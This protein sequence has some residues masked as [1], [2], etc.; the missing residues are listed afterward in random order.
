L[1]I[2]IVTTPNETLKETGLGP[3]LACEALMQSLLDS[4]HMA[5]VTVCETEADLDLVV[6]R[7]PDL[8]VCVVKYICPENVKQIWLS[9]FFE[10][11]GINY[12]G[13]KK[14]NLL[15]DS[16]K[17]SAKLIVTSKGI[18]TAGFFVAIPGQH[19]NETELPLPF[20][21]FIKPSD[22][23]NGN[24][25]DILSLVHDFS[26]F[27]EKVKNLYAE[28]GEPV[29][30]EEYL[31]GMEFTVAVIENEGELIIAPIEVIAQEEGGIRILGS[32]AKNNNNEILR[33]ITDADIMAK[34]VD[35]AGKSFRALGAR[36]FGR[37]DVKM[38]HHG[39]CHFIEA[40]LVPGMK[41]GSSYFPRACEM[42]AGLDYN[43]V[44]RLMIQGATQ[45]NG[46]QHPD[47]AEELIPDGNAGLA[48]AGSPDMVVMPLPG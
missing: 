1:D 14:F 31:D 15:Y 30:V 26:Q 18:A 6:Q 20:P 24:G 44:V 33:F 2:E 42:N 25:V 38:D 37:I 5:V 28:Y 8:V 40:N 36:D 9:E 22:A 10:K 47:I 39:E 46:L 29:L 45:R 11:K 32:T 3:H 16:D 21:L 43:A 27:Q 7:K 13:S 19:L 41:K 17:I 4:H 34:V 48:I 23:A 12:T 35:I